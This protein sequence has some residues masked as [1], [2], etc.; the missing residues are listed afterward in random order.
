MPFVWFDWAYI[1]FFAAVSKTNECP[2]SEES[3]SSQPHLCAS[4]EIKYEALTF[5]SMVLACLAFIFKNEWFI[6]INK[7]FAFS[8]SL[9]FAGLWIC[10]CVCVCGC[11][12]IKKSEY[13]GRYRMLEEHERA[14]EWNW[15][16]EHYIKFQTH[17]ISDAWLQINYLKVRDK[18]SQ[19]ELANSE[20]QKSQTHTHTHR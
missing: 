16:F 9:S 14:K 5:N 4:S 19:N 8:F 11:V 17:A 12:D 6:N 2:L 10:V 1:S 20:S 7:L 13:D 18:I 3:E 15:S